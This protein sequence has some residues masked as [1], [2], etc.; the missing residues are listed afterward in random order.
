MVE[1]LGANGLKALTSSVGDV[2]AALNLLATAVVV[3]PIMTQTYQESGAALK[4]L[5]YVHK[6]RVTIVPIKG[7]GVTT[8]PPLP[9]LHPSTP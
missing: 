1:A 9:P 4:V 2:N 5:T 3:C 8:P 6:Q 7:Q